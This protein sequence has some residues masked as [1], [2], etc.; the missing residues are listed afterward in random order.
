MMSTP[1]LNHN[2]DYNNFVEHAPG[3]AKKDELM[4]WTDQDFH[5]IC[6]LSFWLF[7]S[8]SEKL[9]TTTLAFF[10]QLYKDNSE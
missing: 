5:L 7:C 1:P 2:K 8:A 9:E 4:K 3:K 10:R 6:L